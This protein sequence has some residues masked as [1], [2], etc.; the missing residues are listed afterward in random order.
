[1]RLIEKTKQNTPNPSNPSKRSQWL[2]SSR[3][4]FTVSRLSLNLEG[5]WAALAAAAEISPTE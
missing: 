5:F 3:R 2:Q 4:L 1:M